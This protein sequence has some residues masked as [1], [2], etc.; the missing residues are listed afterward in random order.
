MHVAMLAKARTVLRVE[1]CILGI[2]RDFHGEDLG[3]SI[4]LICDPDVIRCQP[5]FLSDDLKVRC[6]YPS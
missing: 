4:Y 2:G 5:G 6:K 3:G 1:K